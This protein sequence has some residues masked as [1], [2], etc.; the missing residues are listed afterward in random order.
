MKLLNKIFTGIVCGAL[1]TTNVMAGDDCSN[2]TYKQSNPERCKYTQS[3]ESNDILLLG[4][5]AVAIG[6]IAALVGMLAGGS[7]SD[8]G[9][10]STNNTYSVRTVLPTTIVRGST[11]PD[12]SGAELASITSTKEYTR[13]AH[14]YDDIQLAYAF[15]RGYTGDGT[16]IA[17]FDTDLTSQFSHG[18]TV[19]RTIR[20]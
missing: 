12:F 19:M 8:T 5:G 6:G 7:S 16:K 10:P 4:G 1:M 11:A 13:N 15:A 18:A 14:T 20:P 3:A 17:I 2:I 9:T